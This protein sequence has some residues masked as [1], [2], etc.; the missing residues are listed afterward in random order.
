V[1]AER[2]NGGRGP[3]WFTRLASWASYAAGRPASFGIA[4]SLLVIW[5]FLG[6][7]FNFSDSW[8]LVVNTGTTIVTFLMVFLIQHTQNR[9]TTAMQIKLDELIRVTAK[10]RNTLIPLEELEDTELQRLRSELIAL[11]QRGGE[12]A[13]RP[14]SSRGRGA[15]PEGDRQGSGGAD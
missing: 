8:Q 1:A 15:P 14:N 2:D 7:L 3:R 9:D 11:A 6:P 10:A 4:V 13:G 12:T 5:A